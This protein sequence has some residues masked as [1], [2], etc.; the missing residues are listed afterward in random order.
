MSL[1][2]K[3][4]LSAPAVKKVVPLPSGTPDA[5]VPAQVE[6]VLEGLSPFPVAHLCYGYF[7]RPGSGRVLV[8]AAY[9]RRFTVDDA[10]QW[11]EA[12]AVLPAFG[13]WLGASSGGP[14]ALLLQG[15]DFITA[16]GW[17]GAD[18][19]PGVF[20]T[21][22]IS[23]EAPA[24][25][26]TAALAALTASLR[27]LPP[28]VEVPVSDGLRSRVGDDGLEY[29][30]GRLTSRFEA[31]ELDALDVRDKAEVGQRRRERRRDLFFWRVFQGCAVGLLLAA[32]LELGL[33]GGRVWLRTRAAIAA[34]QAPAV[35]NIETKHALAH[36][37]E[38]LS[39]RR[40][41]PMEMISLV[42]AAKLKGNSI[43]FLRTSTKGLNV[44]EIEGQTNSAPDV[45]NYQAALKGLPACQ[46]VEL[47]QTTERGGTT[48]FI[49]TVTF[50][51]DA[52]RPADGST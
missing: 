32:A 21:R 47:G 12:D 40:L 43:Q 38:E 36:R 28:P 31:E 14:L 23:P 42:G 35:Q 19:V 51:P 20:A 18:A 50:K 25:E 17:D 46:D 4:R 3:V 22:Q 9:R 52:L 41:L 44:L 37:I 5:A 34:A 29:A 6:L 15:P 26:R 39:T 27:G 49:L 13:A 30:A 7:H 8:Y 24:E 2:P 16:L 10:S 33:K 1:L 45:F 48:R 11:A